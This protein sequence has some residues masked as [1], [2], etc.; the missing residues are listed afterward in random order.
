MIFSL[1]G[2]YIDIEKP[3]KFNVVFLTHQRLP[4][5]VQTT[6]TPNLWCFDTFK[7]M[8]NIFVSQDEV[9]LR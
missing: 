6:K 5:E 9:A 3:S 8:A 1:I 4:N 2:K 7:S